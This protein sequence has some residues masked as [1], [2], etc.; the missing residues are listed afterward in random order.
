MADWL[1]LD[2]L[3]PPSPDQLVLDMRSVNARAIGMYV[4]RRDGQGNMVSNGSWTAAHVTAIQSDGKYVL[5]ILVPGNVPQQGDMPAAI[6]AAVARGT[7]RTA[8]VV[9]IEQFSFPAPE[10]LQRAIAYAHSVGWRVIRYGDVEPLK[11]YPVADGDWISHGL[12]PVR[13]GQI[14]PVPALPNGCVADQYAVGCSING[15]DYDASVISRDVFS[16]YPGNVG[17]TISMGGRLNAAP[18]LPSRLDLVILGRDRKAYRSWNGGGAGQLDGNANYAAIDHDH[19]PADGW[20]LIDW[21]WDNLNRMV[22]YA[23]DMHGFG[24]VC[25]VRSDGGY[26][27]GWSQL[28]VE[29]AT[30]FDTVPVI[31]PAPDAALR[32]ALKGA[33]DGL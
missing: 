31:Q 3:F 7:G 6:Q 8:M 1:M 22:I 30:P 33:V 25:V 24:Y 13:A 21:T 5:P 20:S 12:I 23:E 4:F 29:V 2:T 10:W 26:D 32:S 14:V 27:Q 11:Q 15:Y 18:W 17:G 9:D 28:P 19:T 16:S